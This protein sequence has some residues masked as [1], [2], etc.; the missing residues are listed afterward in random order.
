MS[1]INL[2]KRCMEPIDKGEAEV[3]GMNGDGATDTYL[4]LMTGIAGPFLHHD[5]LFNSDMQV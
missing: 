3:P 5:F 1:N 4:S 2:A